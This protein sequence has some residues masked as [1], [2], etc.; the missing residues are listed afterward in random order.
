M[1]GLHAPLVNRPAPTKVVGQVAGGDAVEDLEPCVKAAVIGIHVLY[2][3]GATHPLAS[4]QVHIVMR[5]AGLAREGAISVVAI[6]NEQG[7]GG[8]HGRQV[9]RQLAR[10]ERPAPGDEIVGGA[11][12]VTGDEDAHLLVRNAP[13]RG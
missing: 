6:G 7:V 2:M 13:L 5:D 1:R 8:Q 12:A 10:R 4:A 11:T 9:P 3:D